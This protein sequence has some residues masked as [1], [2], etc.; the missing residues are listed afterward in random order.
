MDALKQQILLRKQSMN[1]TLAGK[2]DDEPAAGGNLARITNIGEIAAR[3][4]GTFGGFGFSIGG[5]YQ[6]GDPVSLRK[7]TID[8]LCLRCCLL[9]SHSY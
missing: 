4:T 8:Y 3:Y 2:N 6:F 1:P 5:G 9:S 7:L